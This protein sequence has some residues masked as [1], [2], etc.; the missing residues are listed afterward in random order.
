MSAWWKA[1]CAFCEKAF[2]FP[3]GNVADHIVFAICQYVRTSPGL[4][5]MG[6]GFHC[7]SCSS[8]STFLLT[9]IPVALP[10]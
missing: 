9:V 3:D 1:A 5:S 7:A 6:V 4:R 8:V 10:C 2:R